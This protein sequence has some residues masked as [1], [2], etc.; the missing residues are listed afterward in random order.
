MAAR[1]DRIAIRW[2]GMTR[3]IKLLAAL[4]LVTAAVVTTSALAG[5]PPVP[6]L[7]GPNPMSGK[8]FGQVK[9]R[10]IYQGG[11]ESGLVCRIR[12]LSWGGTLAVGTGTSWYIKPGQV[13]A[14]GKWAPAV[15][16]LYH[17]GTWHGRPAYRAWTW[18]FPGNGSGFGHVSPCKL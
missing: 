17:L 7:T 4:A 11:D 16:V 5:S 2:A 8:G 12:W 13:T 3:R 10:L 1:T 9:P 14:A 18:Y 6:I 15:I